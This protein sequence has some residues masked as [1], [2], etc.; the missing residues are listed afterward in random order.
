MCESSPLVAEPP[1][2]RKNVASITM[3]CRMCSAQLVVVQVLVL[4]LVPV[5]VISAVSALEVSGGLPV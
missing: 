5:L 2:G 1:R 3:N 4:L